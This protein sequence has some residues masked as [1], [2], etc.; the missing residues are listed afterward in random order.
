[1]ELRH[2]RY[3]RAVAELLSF[4][5]AAERLQVGQPALSRQIGGLE[6]ELGTRL[7]DRNRVHVQ[8]TDAGRVFYV[9]ACRILK[10]ADTAIADAREAAAGVAGTLIIC[11][12]R[13]LTS[14][15]IERVIAKFRVTYPRVCVTVFQLPHHEQLTALRTR[16]AHFGLVVGREF[17]GGE[18]LKT[19]RLLTSGLVAVVGASHRLRDATVVRIADLRNEMWLMP[20]GRKL[21]GLRDFIVQICRLS[22][23]VPKVAPVPVP[24]AELGAALAAGGVSLLPEI[25]ARTSVVDPEVR[26]IASDGAPVELQAAW[27][28]DEESKLLQHF[29]EILRTHD[30]A[31]E[32]GVAVRDQSTGR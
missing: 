21:Q 3:V 11:N 14:D 31:G 7:F 20:A 15:L 1:M 28:R 8:L 19:F 13:R 22:G 18:D 23:F 30:F 6:R 10:D 2:L 5:R 9:H 17:A 16:R 32:C 26:L 27:H 24:M 4:S 29:V 25:V 12:D